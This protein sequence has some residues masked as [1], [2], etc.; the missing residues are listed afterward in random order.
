MNDAHLHLVINHFPLIVPIVALLVI[1]TG[2]LVQSDA[3]KR[4][5]LGLL[6]LSALLTFPSMFTGDRAEDMVEKNL[7]ISHDIIHYHQEA[8]ESFAIFSYILGCISVLGLWLSY[9]K[10]PLFHIVMVIIIS[11][12]LVTIYLGIETGTSG[13]EIRHTEIRSDFSLPNNGKHHDD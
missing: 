8:A 12:I 11:L 2:Y 5:A 3:V 10:K 9:K 6:L 4:T 7:E 1:L 13:G